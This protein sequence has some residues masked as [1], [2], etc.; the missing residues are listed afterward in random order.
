M[1]LSFGRRSSK[2][3]P[4]KMDADS[5]RYTILHSFS[6]NDSSRNSL[7]AINNMIPVRIS[8]SSF[9]QSFLTLVV[10]RVI[11]FHHVEIDI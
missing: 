6:F 2:R 8:S 7:L 1:I 10:S 11:V 4:L 3:G 5:E 9:P